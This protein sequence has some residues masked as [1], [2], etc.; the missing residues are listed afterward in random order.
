MS[1]T[2]A[3]STFGRLGWGTHFLVYPTGL[4]VYY[5]GYLPYSERQAK[6]A[7]QEEFDKIC[8]AKKVDPDY[9]NPFSPIPFHNNP[10][11]RYAH[12]EINLRHFVNQN[13]INV[14]N[15]LWKGYSDSYDHGNKKTH[16]YNWTSV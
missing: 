9:F 11:L 4:A 14:D 2:N 1:R 6:A 8:A 10:E 12:A 7:K 15:Y 3:L 13:H 16:L 5:F